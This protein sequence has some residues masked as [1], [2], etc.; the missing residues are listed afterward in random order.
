MWDRKEKITINKDKLLYILDFFD[1]YLMQ[2]I[3]EIL[4]VIQ[5]ILMDSKED[6]H[7]SAVAANNMILCYLEIMTELGQKLPYNSVKEYFEFQGF[8]LEEYDAFERSRI[9][10][11]AYY[12]GPQF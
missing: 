1:V 3:Q 12:R 8:D 5:E 4:M 10:E 7:F 11:S 9:E 6:P 2:F